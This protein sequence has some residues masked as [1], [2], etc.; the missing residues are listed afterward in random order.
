MPLY[1]G[2][3][4]GEE[5]NAD[6]IVT[7]TGFN[8]QRQYPMSNIITSVDDKPYNPGD[9]LLYRGMM[10]SDVPNLF[11]IGSYFHAAY[12]QR[13]D[14][15]SIWVCRLITHMRERGYRKCVVKKDPKVPL[16]EEELMP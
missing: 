5:L 11:Y 14:L 6:V 3:R 8:L 1:M 7:A 2:K 13:V 9:T 4:S 15:V 12:T 16:L 10:L